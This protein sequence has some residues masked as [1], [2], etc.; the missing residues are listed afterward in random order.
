MGDDAYRSMV[1]RVPSVWAQCLRIRLALDNGDV[2]KACTL[3]LEERL[4]GT[5]MAVAAL[6][7]AAVGKRPL[8]YIVTE[9]QEGAHLKSRLT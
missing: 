4:V 8:R 6:V 1:E 2:D 9:P 7:R 3:V 5:E